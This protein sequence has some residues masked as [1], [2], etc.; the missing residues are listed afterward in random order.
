[1]TKVTLHRKPM[2][3]ARHTL[4][5]DYYPPIPHP[6][7]GKLT[8]R[9]FL[10]LY[11]F[12]TPRSQL[13]KQ[14]NRE[15]LAEHIR[16]SRQLDVQ[17]MK[18]GLLSSA[19]RNTSL[20]A[21]YKEQVAKRSGS[22][23]GN[24]QSTLY[25]LQRFFP[26]G[27]RLTELTVAACND[28]K[29]YLLLANSQRSMKTVNNSQSSKKAAKLIS[30]NTAHSYFNKLKATLKQAYKEDL[31]ATD[32]SAKISSIKPAET[33]REYLTMEELQALYKTECPLPVLKRAAIFS[34]LTGLRF[35]DI[36][37]LT[38]SQLQHSQAEGHYLHFRQQKTQGAEK[39]PVSRQVVQL[40]GERG[41]PAAVVFHGLAYSAYNNRILRSWV[42]AAGITKYITF[43]CFRH[44]NATLQLAHGT[45]IYTVS[46]LL[47]HRKLKTTQIYAKVV[48][49]SKRE[50]A[51]R[52]KID[53][54]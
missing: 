23:S 54:S 51:D 43:H 7:T 9:E 36:K 47:G 39:L 49:R 42:K 3:K 12:D 14:H 35:S 18:Y 52:I 32:L 48:D 34:A 1:M 11:V 46:K 50:A 5:L 28:Y 45:D 31:I 30:S 25:Y 26:E 8:R 37:Q 41:D 13:D 33:K 10:G 17:S 44:I 19:R 22:N 16:A 24:W 20:L 38:W 40:L 27:L 29:N 53:L 15:P 6:D 21:Y 4:Y 2:S